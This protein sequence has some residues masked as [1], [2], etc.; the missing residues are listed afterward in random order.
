MPKHL[1]LSLLLVLFLF[2]PLLWISQHNYPS[3]DDF[4]MTLLARKL[5]AIGATKWWYFNFCGRYSYSF[6]Q[7]FI[8]SYE[9]WLTLYKLFPPALMLAGFGC[10][11]YFVRAFFGPGFGGA[12]QFTLSSS[13]YAL[14]IGITPD[15]ATA[16]YWLTSNIQ[17]TGAVFTSLLIFAL[18]IRLGRAENA[19]V[20]SA[21][22]LLVVVLLALLGGLNEASVLFF[23][24][25]L[26]FVNLLHVVKFKKP[27]AW[28]LAF[29]V[30]SVAFGLVSF[31]APGTH[32]RVEGGGAESHLFS[33]LAGSVALT[34]YVLFELLTTTPLLP[35]GVIYFA[36]LHANRDR[37]D[38][39]RSILRGVRWY[40]ILLFILLSVT[41][42]NIV[43][44]TAIGVN[45][46]TD[47]LKNIYVYGIFFGLLLLLTALYNEL[48]AK[49]INLHVPKWVTAVLASFVF[50]F[51]LTGY[52]VEVSRKNVIPSASRSQRMFSLVETGSVYTNAYLDILSGRAE[53]FSRQNH[54]RGEQLTNA[55]DGPVEFSLYSYVPETIFIQD[56]NHSFGAPESLTEV[57]FGEV[58]DLRF[59]ET[60][61]PAP[62]KEKF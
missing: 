33:I 14:L 30:L 3:G 34:F 37:L 13:L 42:V 7:S 22:A 58:K 43:V 39:P 48:S 23:I 17:Y 47:R 21:Y 26:G 6:L 4:G 31:L 54:E 62:P 9:S 12:E 36:F 55:G 32:A 51:L 57:L 44:F 19:T 40:W 1:L 28:C 27:D 24:A 61:P 45:S 15:A 35:A 50:G 5:G 20:K 11:Y 41:A 38:R 2:F 52:E 59:V 25:T 29:F 18:I 46:L 56:V 8:S 10:V 49:K 60:G 16:F 53:R